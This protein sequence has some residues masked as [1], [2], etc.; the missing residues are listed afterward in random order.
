MINTIGALWLEQLIVADACVGEQSPVREHAA[1]NADWQAG[2]HDVA[3]A[4][5]KEI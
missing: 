4:C 2:H 3:V 1:A 5:A